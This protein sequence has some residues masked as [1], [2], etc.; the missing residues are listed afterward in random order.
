MTQTDFAAIAPVLIVTLAACAVLLAES[1]RAKD[2]RM[3]FELL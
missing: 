3:P 1:F 2:E